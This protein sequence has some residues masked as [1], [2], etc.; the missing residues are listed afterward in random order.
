[1]HI[2]IVYTRA[3]ARTTQTGVHNTFTTVFTNVFKDMNHTCAL[4]PLN[5]YTE[6][7]QLYM[8]QVCN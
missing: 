7:W 2:D 1:M 4:A 3:R 8:E 6:M 5:V